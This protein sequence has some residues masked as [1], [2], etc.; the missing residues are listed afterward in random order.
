MKLEFSRQVFL[1]FKY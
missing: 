1:I